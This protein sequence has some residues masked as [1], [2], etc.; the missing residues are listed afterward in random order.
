MN[1]VVVNSFSKMNLTF[2][3][4]WKRAS[5]HSMY[6][7]PWLISGRNCL[8]C[9]SPT[10]KTRRRERDRE[11][12]CLL[13]CAEKKTKMEISKEEIRVKYKISHVIVSVSLSLR[14]GPKDI[15]LQICTS[16]HQG[17]AVDWVGGSLS[18]HYFSKGK[19]NWSSVAICYETSETYSH[20]SLG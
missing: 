2:S 14:F 11:S 20:S 3:Q 13:V 9:D 16:R 8:G 1:R 5:R 4:W 12:F 10:V 15:S 6:P 17:N 18:H 19:D 7:R